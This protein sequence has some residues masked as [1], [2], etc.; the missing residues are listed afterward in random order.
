MDKAFAPNSDFFNKGVK[1][2]SVAM[3]E[4]SIYT[5]WNPEEKQTPEVMSAVCAV[6]IVSREARRALRIA[7]RRRN[8]PLLVNDFLSLSQRAAMQ[9]LYV[10]TLASD[11]ASASR[12]LSVIREP[13][14]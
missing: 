9:A 5:K 4:V 7:T 13:L 11:S 2:L 1:L 6:K 12:I 14:M 3:T 10:M 8:E